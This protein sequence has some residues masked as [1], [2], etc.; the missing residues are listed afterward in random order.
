MNEKLTWSEEKVVQAAGF[1]LEDVDDRVA[2]LA[3]KALERCYYIDRATDEL[4]RML[5]CCK[6]VQWR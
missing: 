2:I 1:R 5:D 3:R 4:L 6:G